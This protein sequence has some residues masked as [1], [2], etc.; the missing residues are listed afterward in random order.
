VRFTQ[1]VIR[2]DKEAGSGDW[3]V[4]ASFGKHRDITIVNKIEGA[5][6]QTLG[7]PGNIYISEEKS[8]NLSARLYEHD[9]GIGAKWESV[10]HKETLVS[11]NGLHKLEF[12]NDEGHVELHFEVRD[13]GYWE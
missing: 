5:T 1:L 10:G 9:G 13:I 12:R 4:K 6:G 7:L 8:F 11:R 2:D 3:R